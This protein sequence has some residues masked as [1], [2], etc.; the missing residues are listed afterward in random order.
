MSITQSSFSKAPPPSLDHLIEYTQGAIKKQ[1][2]TIERLED[3]G[4][5]VTDAAKHLTEM[6]GNLAALKQIKR[7]GR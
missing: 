7:T 6:V 2:T 5:E 3:Q 4:H 1:A